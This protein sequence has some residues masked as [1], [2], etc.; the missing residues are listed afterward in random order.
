[1]TKRLFKFCL[2]NCFFF[3]LLF[4][5]R[6]QTNGNYIKSLNSLLPVSPNA[7]SIMKY[8]DVPVTLSSG[9]PGINIPIHT[10]DEN[11]LQLPISLSY[12]AGGIK[13]DEPASWVGLAWSLSAGGAI[14][15]EVRGLPDDNEAEIGFFSFVQTNDYYVNHASAKLHDSIIK[16]ASIGRLD[17]EPDVFYFNAAGISGKFAFDQ[18]TRTF[19]CL[20]QQSVKIIRNAVNNTWKVVAQDGTSYYFENKEMTTSTVRC[21]VETNN[22]NNVISAWYLSKVVNANQTDSIILAYTQ[23]DYDF[24]SQGSSTTYTLLTGERNMNRPNLNCLSHNYI[25]GI[26]RLSSIQSRKYKI[27]FIPATTVRQDMKDD[28]ALARINVKNATGQLIKSF[29]FNYDYYLSAGCTGNIPDPTRNQKRLRLLSVDERGKI[30]TDSP[31]SHKFTYNSG[32]LPCRLSYSQDFWG[33]ANGAT[34]TNPNTLVPK[35][36]FY[37]TLPNGN[38]SMT[39]IPGAD[40]KSN[41]AAMLTG[42]LSKIEYPTGGTTSFD[43]EANK[44]GYQPSKYIEP[45][46]KN[47]AITLSDIKYNGEFLDNVYELQFVINEPPS[48]FNGNRGGALASALAEPMCDAANP[49]ACGDYILTGPQTLTFTNKFDDVYLPNGTYTLTAS[50]A[51]INDIEPPSGFRYFSASIFYPVPDTPAT[52]NVINYTVGGLRIKRIINVDS[53]GGK[54]ATIRDFSYSSPEKDSSYGTLLSIPMFNHVESIHVTESIPQGGGFIYD[55]SHFVRSGNSV[56]PAVTSQ[57]GYVFYPKVREY[58]KGDAGNQRTDYEFTYVPAETDPGYPITPTY[59]P[60]W[61]RGNSLKTIVYKTVD[62]TYIPIQTTTNDYNFYP[63]SSSGQSFSKDLLG[64]LAANVDWVVNKSADEEFSTGMLE[65]DVLPTQNLYFLPTGR[66]YKRSDT[67][68]TIDNSGNRLSSVNSYKYGD[69]AQQLIEQSFTDSKGQLKSVKYSY[70]TDGTLSNAHINSTVLN[71]LISENRMTTPLSVSTN[72]NSTELKKELLYYSYKANVLATDSLKTSILTNAPDLDAAILQYDSYGNPLTIKQRDGLFRKYTWSKVNGLAQASSITPTNSNIAFTSFEY[73]NELTWVE[74]G[75][76]TTKALSG[77][78]AYQLSA[79]SI[80]VSSLDASAKYV[81]YIWIENG[82]NCTLD[83]TGMEYSGRTANGWRLMRAS[84]TGKTQCIISGSGI[85]DN[86]M[87]IPES[88]SFEGNV[89]DDSYQITSRMDARAMIIFYEYDNMGRLKVIR[90][91]DRNIL[92]QMDYQYK[93]PLT[94]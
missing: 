17:L 31:L 18:E 51:R 42:V 3:F 61:L 50:V 71:R 93:A 23:L 53:I 7:N 34:N 52:T 48:P 55:V 67:T 1:M 36:T 89:Y 94:K 8:G 81:V 11:G 47:K 79:G 33:Y 32:V 2:L 30:D 5:T 20:P 4:N 82:A 68:V 38:I 35:E 62:T 56:V 19:T 84:L 22:F 69:K 76:T 88:A 65:P 86:L 28:Y 66:F 40:R 14:T 15:R 92:K 87:V 37:T 63:L 64:I 72:S 39:V 73:P 78:S 9:I 60:D 43:F 25:S 80:T 27:E 70:P 49:T 59:D 85:A 46:S 90:D 41:E 6:A 75:R 24:Y 13:V 54:P 91:Q 74:T 21:D 26:S 57:G 77:K 29:T 12:H 83:G 44:I 10:V 16:E 58:A 45:K